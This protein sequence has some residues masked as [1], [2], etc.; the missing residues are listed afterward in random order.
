M[1][2]MLREYAYDR[3][4]ENGE[5]AGAQRR[6]GEYVLNFS[7]RANAELTGGRSKATRSSASS[8]STRTSARRWNGRRAA[9]EPRSALNC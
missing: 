9:V 5:L 8:A 2:E 6:H 7:Q 3:L 4:A 1:L